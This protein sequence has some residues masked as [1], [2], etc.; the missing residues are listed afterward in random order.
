MF[1]NTVQKLRNASIAQF[2]WLQDRFWLSA[3]FE[4]P[5]ILWDRYW[6]INRIWHLH[7]RRMVVRIERVWEDVYDF[8]QNF[9]TTCFSS[10]SRIL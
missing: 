2:F 8:Y 3:V 10:L 9:V 6:E 5:S 4:T 7:H 1:Y